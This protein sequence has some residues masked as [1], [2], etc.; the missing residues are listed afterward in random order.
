MWFYL[1]FYRRPAWVLSRLQSHIRTLAKLSLATFL[2]TEPASFYYC[3]IYWLLERSNTLQKN[4]LKRYQIVLSVFRRR[5]YAI[6]SLPADCHS[7]LPVLNL[8]SKSVA[9]NQH[10][11]PCR[12]NYA[13]DRKKMID[14]PFRIVTTFSISVQSLFG[15]DRTT[16]AG[17]RSENWCFFCS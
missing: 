1:H 12:K 17:C 3:W 5:L 14:N 4:I 7:N 6:S 15:G 2:L 11:R 8:L 13:L 9:K 16:S 10:F